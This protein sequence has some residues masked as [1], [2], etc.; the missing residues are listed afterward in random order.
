[1]PTKLTHCDLCQKDIS[2]KNWATHTKTKRH[3][4]LVSGKPIE[5]K[6]PLRTRQVM[7]KNQ[8]NY[9]QRF[10]EDFENVA[11]FRAYMAKKKREYR[12]KLKEKKH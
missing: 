1:M 7:L 4:S 3:Q 12:K 2:T 8:H 5:Y 10:K 9:L 6:T 11:D